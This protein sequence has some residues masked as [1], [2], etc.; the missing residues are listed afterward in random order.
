MDRFA[1]GKKLGKKRAVLIS[2]YD[3]R[4]NYPDRVVRDAAE[5][6][7]NPERHRSLLVFPFNLC[8]TER[9]YGTLAFCG[10][11]FEVGSF[12]TEGTGCIFFW[13][14]AV[15]TGIVLVRAGKVTILSIGEGLRKRG[16]KE[17][18]NVRR[19]GL[20]RWRLRLLELEVTS[21]KSAPFGISFGQASTWVEEDHIWGF[22]SCELWRLIIFAE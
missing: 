2:I 6:C 12:F 14:R 17:V 21:G 7:S 5:S 20:E 9:F 15:G 8:E 1:P 10:H 13:R 16:R 11:N 19:A 18:G 4:P 22:Y 3:T